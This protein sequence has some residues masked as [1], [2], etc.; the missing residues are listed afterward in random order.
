MCGIAGIVA[1]RHPNEV[2]RLVERMNQIQH[3]RGPDG[4]GGLL[5]SSRPQ[6]F[7][8][9]EDA[10]AANQQFEEQRY[11][12]GLG[13]R[14]LSII[15]L[16]EQARQP[17]PNEN[18]DLWL[19]YNGE[20][21]NFPTLRKELVKNGH[22]FRSQTD[23][24]VIVHLYE[25]KGLE[26]M[27]H[28]EG[29]FAFALWDESKR[30][31]LLVRDP[32]GIKPLYW[33]SLPC[34][35]IIFASE[36]KA[37]FQDPMLSKA[38][39]PR[40]FAEHFTFQWTVDDVTFFRDVHLLP[41]GCALEWTETGPRVFRYHNLEYGETTLPRDYQSQL[42]RTFQEAVERH[43]LSDV[44]IGSYLSGGMDT[45]SITSVAV[46]RLPKLHTFTCGF[47]TTDIAG[48]ERAYD[49]RELSWKVARHF[50]TKHHQ[51]VLGPGQGMPAL[52]RVVWHLDEPRCG[53]SYQNYYTAGMIKNYVKVVLSGV[54]GDE[55]Y[56]GYPWRYEPI[57]GSTNPD[58]DYYKLWIRFLDDK[59]KKWL[60]SD[61]LNSDLKDFSTFESFQKVMN[62][63]T[64][65]DPLHRALYFDSY[66]FLNGLLLVE[67][68]LS[69]AHSLESRVP[70]LD[71]RLTKL[72][73]SLPSTVKLSEGE[74]KVI[75]KQAL[76]DLLPPEILQA[77]KQ[78]FTPPEASW[79]RGP[80]RE[81]VETFLRQPRF[82]E[83]GLFRREGVER[84]L[85][86][87]MSQQRNH[88]FLIWSLMSVEWMLRFFVDGE[89]P[90]EPPPFEESHPTL[91]L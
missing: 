27:E 85:R 71:S 62:R 82:L 36:I 13:H 76:K 73:T 43:L 51:M 57:L 77:P 5:I 45:G 79:Y 81:A 10:L 74:S 86:E 55:F 23:S 60:F 67:D 44:P 64:T 69:M 20:I 40:A 30:R 6:E 59:E 29:M 83:R 68:K 78:G 56:A 61:S 11:T 34:G 12:V 33:A 28:L 35:G 9:A 41:Q 65:S 24:E 15:D 53:I 75:L 4:V 54:G 91:C 42:R 38:L 49:E 66:T 58:Q 89:A 87:H 37:L 46:R 26:L 32:L 2:V 8:T 63:C 70:F 39:D 14:R 16:S 50:D 47:E 80:S 88:R 1:R 3:H 22:Q 90:P 84:V 18:R 7:R 31:L 25:E 52:P 21:Y 72:A 48:D 19:T 17:I